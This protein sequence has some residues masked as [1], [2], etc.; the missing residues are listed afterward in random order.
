MY[1]GVKN[2]I[3]QKPEAMAMNA[4]ASQPHEDDKDATMSKNGK[5]P[6]NKTSK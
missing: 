3:T 6:D 5:R 1:V 4:E 2:Q